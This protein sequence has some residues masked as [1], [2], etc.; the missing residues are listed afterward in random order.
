M[1]GQLTSEIKDELPD[2][3]TRFF[4]QLL[5]QFSPTSSLSLS[6]L[7]YITDSCTDTKTLTGSLL[8]FWP[9]ELFPM[10]NE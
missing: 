7:F 4:F 1:S 2:T 3:R 9:L 6:L 8:G 10:K 5:N